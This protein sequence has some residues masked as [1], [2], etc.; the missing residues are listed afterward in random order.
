MGGVYGDHLLSFPELSKTYPYFD[1]PALQGGGYGTPTDVGTARGAFQ[2]TGGRR[3]K[4]SNGNLV[5]SRETRFWTRQVLTV[6]RFLLIEGDTYRIGLPDNSWVT[7]GGF[8][9]Y[10]LEKVV[11]GDGSEPVVP[12]W[13]RGERSFG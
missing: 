9:V 7:E 10:D 2:C 1:Q 5:V 3:V 12:D 11:G 4:D 6:G 13:D 8:T